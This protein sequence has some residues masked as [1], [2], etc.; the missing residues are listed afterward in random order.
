[1]PIDGA[2]VTVTGISHSPLHCGWLQVERMTAIVIGTAWSEAA[3]TTVTRC[4]CCC[5]FSGRKKKKKLVKLRGELWRENSSPSGETVSVCVS[6][7]FGQVTA[8]PFVLV[9]VCVAQLS[10]FHLIMYSDCASLT[11]VNTNVRLMM[12]LIICCFIYIFIYF[13]FELHD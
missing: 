13:M 12:G 11:D 9:C 1:M 5:T 6:F 2:N 8:L 10:F 4:C 7:S 3:L